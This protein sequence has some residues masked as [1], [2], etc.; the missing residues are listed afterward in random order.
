[1]GFLGSSLTGALGLVGARTVSSSFVAA[2]G[3]RAALDPSGLIFTLADRFR[4]ARRV[5]ALAIACSGCVELTLGCVTLPE[6]MCTDFGL[7]A[8]VLCWIVLLRVSGTVLVDWV[9]EWFAIVADGVDCVV[10]AGLR[11]DCVR[12]RLSDGVAEGL[13]NR[14]GGRI[15]CAV[16]GFLASWF[17]SAGADPV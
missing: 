10:T 1:M 16:A 17:F 3:R 15:D 7:S 8:F 5:D 11:R 12:P 9:R 6:G 4:P 13:L 14:L 2:R